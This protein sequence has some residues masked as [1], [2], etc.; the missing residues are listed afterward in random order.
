ML[1]PRKTV[2][3]KRQIAAWG[4]AGAAAGNVLIDIYGC[5]PRIVLVPRVWLERVTEPA[6]DVPGAVSWSAYSAARSQ[7]GNLIPLQAVDGA[8]ARVI[9]AA[10]EADG[11]IPAGDNLELQMS[12]DLILVVACVA[13]TVP[14]SAGQTLW[15]GLDAYPADPSVSPSDFDEILHGIHVSEPGALAIQTA[16]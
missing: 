11:T 6:G 9:R 10:T 3:E 12:T 4:S 14:A 13:G 5:D 16:S 8:L 1:A 2:L 15:F 7:Y